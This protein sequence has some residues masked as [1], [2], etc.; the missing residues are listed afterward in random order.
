MGALELG[1]P[2][3]CGGAA[4]NARR[5]GRIAMFKYEWIW[6]KTIGSGQL[7]ARRQPLRMHES[8]LVFYKKPGTY[9]ARR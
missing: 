3:W 2:V 4:V 1:L 7:N 8:I 6:A 5:C 9:N